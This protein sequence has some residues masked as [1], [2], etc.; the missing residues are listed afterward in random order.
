MGT[1]LWHKLGLEYENLGEHQ[2][3]KISTPIRVY[4][5]LSYPGAAAHRVIQAKKAVRHKWRIVAIALSVIMILAI[6]AVAIWERYF[7]LPPVEIVATEDK[8]FNLPKGPK[9]AV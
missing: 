5:V 6:A 7:H 8:V 9:V 2:V 3:K 1:P 4:R